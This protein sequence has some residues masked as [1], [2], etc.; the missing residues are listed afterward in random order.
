VSNFYIIAREPGAENFAIPTWANRDANP[1]ALDPD[2]DA[3]I[4]RRDV[5]NV[6]GAFQLLNVLSKDECE[7]VIEL[8][9]GLGYL[10][11]A[12]VSLPRAV[13]HND[14]F[15][16][17]VD[18]ATNDIIWRRCRPRLGDTHEYNLDK[19]VRGINSRFRFYRYRP[20]DYF[21]PHTDGSWP[22]SRVID[23]ELVANAHRD[24]WS[25]FSLLLFLS[26]DYEG[27]A[28]R[29]YVSPDD[30]ERPPGSPDEAVVI[31]VRT[32]IGGALCFPHGTH[33]L[34]RMHASQEITRGIK[35]IIRTDILFDL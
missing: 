26:E 30:P 21:A 33:P 27:G 23:G 17:V 14:S 12:A 24:Q 3:A 4:E 7:R 5:A 22:G 28:T 2:R 13:R 19:R 1:A 25:Q 9:E 11:D 31:D 6:P 29:F 20:G 32:P 8:S 16:W 10:E 15:T 18:D 34:H 35:Y